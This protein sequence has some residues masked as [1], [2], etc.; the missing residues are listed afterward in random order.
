M[1]IAQFSD[2]PNNI[3][4]TATIATPK[5]IQNLE[6]WLRAAKKAIPE[7]PDPRDGKFKILHQGANANFVNFELIDQYDHRVYL[8]IQR[9]AAAL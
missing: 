9:K 1:P 5:K 2:V 6:H 4:K 3:R 8:T 7:V